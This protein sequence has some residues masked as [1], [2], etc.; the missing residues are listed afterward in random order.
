MPFFR[1]L[2]FVLSEFPEIFSLVSY[3]SCSPS[4]IRRQD[5]R[6][7]ESLGAFTFSESK[8]FVS[9]NCCVFIHLRRPAKSRENSDGTQ[10]D[11]TSWGTSVTSET[12][13]DNNH[14]FG[15]SERTVISWYISY[16][17]DP[18]GVLFSRF[19]FSP[20][21]GM[22]QKSGSF[23]EIYGGDFHFSIRTHFSSIL[24]QWLQPETNKD[25]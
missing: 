24:Y 15:G 8:L 9:R 23:K 5:P 12:Y 17:D 4:Q 11:T 22:P 20:E 14:H 21:G 6:H 18:T 10:Q 19:I 16:T 25:C 1:S 2:W 3:I 7:H 13:G